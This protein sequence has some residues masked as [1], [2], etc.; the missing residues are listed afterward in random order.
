MYYTHRLVIS[1]D[2]L[3]RRVGYSQAVAKS[4]DSAALGNSTGTK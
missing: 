3:G 2:T 1:N 4:A